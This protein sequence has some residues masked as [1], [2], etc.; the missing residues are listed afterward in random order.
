MG[1]Y[2][3]RYNDKASL[4]HLINHVSVRT[5]MDKDNSPIHLCCC[6]TDAYEKLDW[7]FLEKESIVDMPPTRDFFYVYDCIFH[8]LNVELPFDDFTM[9]ILRILNMAHLQLHPNG[10]ATMQ[11]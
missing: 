9:S 6:R 8:N 3:S 10:W 7:V 2:Y 4:L 11:V 5:L 1:S